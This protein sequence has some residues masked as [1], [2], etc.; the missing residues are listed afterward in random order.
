MLR[1]K[2]FLSYSGFLSHL[3]TG[4]DVPVAHD[5]RGGL[6][7]APGRRAT[8]GLGEGREGWQGWEAWEGCDST[9]Y[10]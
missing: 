6:Q 5:P 2:L 9:Q 8:G 10:C 4:R 3:C 1:A 7:S